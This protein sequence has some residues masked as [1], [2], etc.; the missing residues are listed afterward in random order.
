MIFDLAGAFG[1]R[2]YTPTGNV[3]TY[4][5]VVERSTVD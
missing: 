2:S 3:K 4:L 1:E 5:L